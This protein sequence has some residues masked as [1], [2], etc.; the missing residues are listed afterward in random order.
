[1]AEIVRNTPLAALHSDRHKTPRPV[2]SSPHCPAGKL[3]PLFA[4]APRGSAALLAPMIPNRKLRRQRGKRLAV[5]LLAERLRG[6]K[7][8]AVLLAERLRGKKLAAVLMA[9]R[10]G[11]KKLAVVLLAEKLRGKK[12]AAVLLAERLGGKKL[13]DVLLG[14]SIYLISRMV[15]D[16]AAVNSR[17]R[18]RLRIKS[19]PFGAE[20]C[21]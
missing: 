5:V 3:A 15:Y 8:A 13:A 6:K 10:L 1:M 21:E 20:E 11:G 17:R 4:R 16:F 19:A 7:L 18:W 2:F 9:E 12:L 14:L